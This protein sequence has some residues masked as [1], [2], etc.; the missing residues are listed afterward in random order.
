MRPS[1]A[2]MLSHPSLADIPF[3]GAFVNEGPISWIA[4]NSSKPGRTDNHSWVI[5]GS[6]DWSEQNIDATPEDVLQT[7]GAAFESLVGKQIESPI[8]ARAHRWRYAIPK[9]PLDCEFLL[10][11][12][13][14][15]GACGDW[16]AGSRVERAFLSGM[17]TAGALLR[18]V[19]IDRAPASGARSQHQPKLF[20]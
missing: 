12:T 6:A 14:G 4:N 10:D 11:M 19:T 16:C 18:H 2:V 1:W 3:D 13:T 9:N 8:Y 7:L 20:A 17:A 5:H 15:L